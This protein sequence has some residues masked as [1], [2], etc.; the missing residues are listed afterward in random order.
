MKANSVL[1]RTICFSNNDTISKCLCGGRSY[2]RKDYEIH[3]REKDRRLGG[4]NSVLRRHGILSKPE[5]PKPICEPDP[6]LSR[7]FCD[8]CGLSYDPETIHIGS[9]T[10]ITFD[11]AEE[12]YKEKLKA[13]MKV[14]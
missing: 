11:S 9:N 2:T 4:Q 5:P 7:V 13:W 6:F 14:K 12:E 10:N 1:K 3:V 8:S